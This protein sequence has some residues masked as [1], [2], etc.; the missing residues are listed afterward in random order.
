MNGFRH[1]P[2]R[3][4]V[5]GAGSF[6]TAVAVLLDRAG[7]RTT[8]FCRSEEQARALADRHENERY[9]PGVRIPDGVKIRLLGGRERQFDRADL[10]FLA[11]PS[12]GLRTAI[13]LLAAQG[14]SRGAGVVS[15]ARGLVPPDGT[16][17]TVALGA[18][19]P[20]V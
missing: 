11:V 15:L 5:I 12:S 1:A 7:I 13:D 10:V 18:V 14:T 17:P 8:L 19:F 16:P 3:A 9:L 2:R 20:R 4:S 6:G